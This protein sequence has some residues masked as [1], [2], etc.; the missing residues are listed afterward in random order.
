M[1]QP[2]FLLCEFAKINPYFAL[3][4]GQGDQGSRWSPI[5][6]LTAQT[7][8]A[9]ERLRQVIA[10]VGIRLRTPRRWIAASIMFQGWAARLTSIYA[11]SIALGGA[12]PSLA[13][14][15]LRFRTGGPT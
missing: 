8:E 6:A 4:D 11:G 10:D 13:A 9:S 14:T 5:S 2:Q 1:R 15:H 3:V 12:V 7:P